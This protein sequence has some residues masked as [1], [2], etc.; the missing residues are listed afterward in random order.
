MMLEE[1]LYCVMI[2]V[3]DKSDLTEDQ[4]WEV[5]EWGGC[6][7][8]WKWERE[9]HLVRVE[10]FLRYICRKHEKLRMETEPLRDCWKIW[11]V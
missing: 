9:I 7:F 11:Q 1:V 10:N 5:K 8:Q 3:T 6:P 4:T 2:R